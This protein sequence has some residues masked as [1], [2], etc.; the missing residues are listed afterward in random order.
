M[1]KPSRILNLVLLLTALVAQSGCGGGSSSNTTPGEF[2]IAV[3]PT[4]ASVPVGSDRQFTAEARDSTGDVLT[5]VTFTWHSSDTRIAIPVG[6][7]SF[8]GIAV[9]V[10]NITASA[11]IVIK[12]GQGITNIVSPA[13][14]LSVI[15]GVEGT[16]ARGA[17][18]AD[19]SVS[20]RDAE[21]QYAATS[22]DA[23][24]HF[25]IETAGMTGPFLLKATTPD[26]RVLY[27]MA[28][29]VGTANVDP[30]TD[31]LVR[32]WYAAHGADPDQAFAG[33]AAL[34]QIHDLQVSDQSL[35][36]QLG[37]ELTAHGLD[38]AHFS[39]LNTPFTA[40]HSGFDAVVDQSRIN[41]A[42]RSI[43]VEGKSLQ[44]AASP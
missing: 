4:S 38:A 26:G 7:G 37:P 28:A 14:P 6:G 3:L 18:L 36:K 22:A 5:G 13:V 43:Q 35:V 16:A 40:D 10:A 19:A 17:P 21:G 25:Q 41:P 2:T 31:V 30:Y 33:Q 44:L 15:S 1:R 27:G 34:P 39:L 12:A 9:G 23:N 32:N 24:G 8:R 42:S 29:D 20:L 11:S